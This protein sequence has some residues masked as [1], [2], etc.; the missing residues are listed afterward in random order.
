MSDSIEM[1]D[2]STPRPPATNTSSEDSAANSVISTWTWVVAAL[3]VVLASCLTVFPGLLLFLSETAVTAGRRSELTPLE[4]FLAVHFGIW[5]TAIAAALVLNIPSPTDSYEVQLVS[6]PTHPL[7]APLSVA[8]SVTSFLSYN[9]KNVGPLASIVFA[10]SAII[11][12]W[13]LWAIVFGN[14]RSVSKTTGA[15][16]H[17]SSFIFGNK[18]AASVQKKQWRKG[19]R[20]PH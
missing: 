16:K 19:Q 12:L 13:G 11:G 4:S 18:S 2:L 6:S 8:A 7:L 5:L 10:G 9:T 1:A 17:T 20:K 15:D 3:L 14:S